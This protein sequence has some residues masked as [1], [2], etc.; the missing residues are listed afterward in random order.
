MATYVTINVKTLFMCM[1]VALQGCT[2]TSPS[3][4]TIRVSCELLEAYERI[5][6]TISSNSCTCSQPITM[7]DDNPIT[8]PNLTT[9]VYTVEVTAVNSND[10]SIKDNKIVEM[11]TL[12]DRSTATGESGMY[13]YINMCVPVYQMCI[14]CTYLT[15]IAI[16][17]RH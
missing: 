6:I 12:C 9:G 14:L 13:K 8:V 1:H 4:Y 11:I 10:M 7:V 17:G 16:Y 3:A 2:I 15:Y 5:R